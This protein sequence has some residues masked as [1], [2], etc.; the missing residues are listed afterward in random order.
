MLDKYQN[1]YKERT[2]SRERA[3]YLN[4]NAPAEAAALLL[5]TSQERLA[6]Q[7]ARKNKEQ[8]QS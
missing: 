6:K 3:Q 4:L 7:A 8:L 1:F 5:D 2:P